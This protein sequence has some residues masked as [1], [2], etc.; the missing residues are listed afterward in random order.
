M[1]VKHLEGKVNPNARRL[2][3]NENEVCKYCGRKAYWY[4]KFKTTDGYC[5]E[6]YHGDCPTIKQKAIAAE[7]KYGKNYYRFQKEKRDKW[8][9]RMKNSNPDSGLL[10]I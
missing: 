7:K 5:C 1:S 4:L 10:T 8:A 2:T 9:A 3:S 6:Q